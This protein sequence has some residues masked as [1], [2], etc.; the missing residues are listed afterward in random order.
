[1]KTL[2]CLFYVVVLVSFLSGAVIHVPDQA[3]TIQ[4]GINQAQRN[5]TVLVAEGTYYE[6]ISFKGKAIT[7]TS[8]FILDRKMSHIKKTII[9]GSKATNPDSGSVVYFISGE[10]TNSVLSGFTIT[11]GKGTVWYYKTYKQRSG[12]GLF[13]RYGCTVENNIVTKNSM[14]GDVGCGAGLDVMTEAAYVSIIRN[15][16]IESNNIDTERAGVAGAQLGAKGR[17]I[18]SHNSIINNCTYS[19]IEG[20]IGGVYCWGDLVWNGKIEIYGNLIQGNIAKSNYP[21]GADAGGLL[22]V[23]TSPDV[24]KNVISYNICDGTGG[25]IM[26]YLESAKIYP[27]FINDTIVRNKS[28]IYGGAISLHGPDVNALVRNCIVWDNRALGAPMEIYD[29][30]GLL[31][32]S[33]TNIQGGWS[34]DGTGNTSIDPK[35][36]D[37]VITVDDTIF[38]CLSSNSPCIDGGDPNP[39]YFDMEDVN[40]PGIAKWP[41]M[42]TIKNDM[43]VY[44]G[45]YGIITGIDDQNEDPK[46]PSAVI[47]HQNYPNPF[48]PSTVI[49]FSIPESRNVSLTIFDLLGRTVTTLVEA[50]LNAGIYRY[51]WQPHDVPTGIYFYRLQC[52]EFNETKKM[53]LIR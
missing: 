22:V 14:S 19:T 23:S 13:I 3:P 33:Y 25:G 37:S 24:I 52:G 31:D 34:G 46:I 4:Q 2:C 32:V 38:C 42:G 39:Y 41:A 36:I 16:R 51:K 30:C 21:T 29:Q 26:V 43:G 18:F 8:H 27:R 6:N 12:G 20:G 44:G 40:T 7:V 35:L 11:G 47:L 15:N 48:N 28:K 10:D 45:R 53:V 49:E 50:R 1:M 5:D 17:L 9:D